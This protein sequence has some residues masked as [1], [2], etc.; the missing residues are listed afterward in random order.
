MPN[1]VNLAISRTKKKSTISP[2]AYKAMQN[3]WKE[4]K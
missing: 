3:K 4:K 2:E 1:R